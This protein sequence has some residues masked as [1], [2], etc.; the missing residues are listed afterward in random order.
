MPSATGQEEAEEGD[1][2][3]IAALPKQGA[4]AASAGPIRTIWS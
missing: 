4:V 3:R 2:E 1:G